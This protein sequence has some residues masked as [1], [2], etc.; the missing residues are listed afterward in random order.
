MDAKMMIINDWLSKN[1]V[2]GICHLQKIKTRSNIYI[3]DSK[4]ELKQV[5]DLFAKFQQSY[6]IP[7]TT[8]HLQIDKIWQKPYFNWN[9]QFDCFTDKKIYRKKSIES[10]PTVHPEIS[11][12][13]LS[14]KF[15]SF[16]NPSLSQTYQNKIE[17][18][19][20]SP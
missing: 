4:I 6:F 10:I 8:Q 12:L 16:F 9:N 17:Y 1:V 11:A 2:K 13:H 19:Q 3:K 5:T 15:G 18:F 14:V 7:A 20:N